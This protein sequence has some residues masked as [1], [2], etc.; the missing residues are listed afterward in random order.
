MENKSWE[1]RKVCTFENFEE[2]ELEG[3]NVSDFMR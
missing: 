2:V 1:K 3:V